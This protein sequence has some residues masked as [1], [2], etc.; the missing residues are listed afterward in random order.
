MRWL[1]ITLLA[2]L[3]AGD[4]IDAKGT[5]GVKRNSAMHA[6]SRKRPPPKKAP[7]RRRRDFDGRERR[8]HRE[9]VVIAA[10][11]SQDLARAPGDGEATFT[12]ENRDR[13]AADDHGGFL[14]VQL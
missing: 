4:V 14:D 11:I 12:R 3:R 1:T 7:K 13:A 2:L 8:R 9:R 6:K 10:A 5:K